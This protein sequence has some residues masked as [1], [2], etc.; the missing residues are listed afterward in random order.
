MGWNCEAFL[1]RKVIV[2]NF[3]CV[4]V[5]VCLSM[6][7]CK[8]QIFLLWNCCNTITPFSLEQLHLNKNSLTRICYPDEDM[9]SDLLSNCES[10]EKSVKPFK[11]LRCLLLGNSQ[12]DFNCLLD[13]AYQHF[14]SLLI[15]YMVQ[16]VIKLRTWH[17]LTPLILSLSWR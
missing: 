17:L 14:G 6:L 16:E 7:P 1:A 2:E 13:L 9:L 10:T 3:Y 5:N 11:N 12:K 15:C 8:L 4:L